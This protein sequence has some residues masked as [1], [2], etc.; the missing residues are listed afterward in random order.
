MFFKNFLL[1][2]AFFSFH[3][4]LCYSRIQ[5]IKLENDE[6]R[7]IQLSSFGYLK[8]GSFLLK[9]KNFETKNHNI[10]NQ[11]GFTLDKSSSEGRS[12]YVENQENSQGCT[13][14]INH[15]IHDDSNRAIM[16][17]EQNTDDEDSFYLTY[18]TMR[19]EGLS[20]EISHLKSTE[21]TKKLENQS[22]ISQMNH[23][24]RNKRD[25]SNNFE[26]VGKSKV[27]TEVIDG[28]VH[29]SLNIS[30]M[31]RTL[32]QEGLYELYFHNCRGYGYQV[33]GFGVSA[34]I[35]I[36]EKNGDNY[37]SAGDIFLPILYAVMSACFL[38]IAIQWISILCVNKDKVFVIHYMMLVLVL[39]KGLSLAFHSINLYFISKDGTPE[40]WAI[41]FYVVHL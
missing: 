38:F 37:L 33:E 3:L 31:I 27:K 41:I 35:D 25:L 34:S 13:L 28:K 39:I 30:S 4:N 12:S 18:Y 40:T 14:D 5:S 29:F 21:A 15:K 26:K 36:I 2:F 24:S 7:F 6:R 23:E 17:L 10:N 9:I 8:G 22:T 32:E 19:L 16:R 20:F 11:I 1:I